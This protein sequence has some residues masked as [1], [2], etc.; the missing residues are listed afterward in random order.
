MRIR[1][2]WCLIGIPALSL[3]LIV[4]GCGGDCSST[5][6][7]CRSS[8]ESSPMS[9]V[10]VSEAG[11]HS[12]GITASGTA[13]CWG[14][15]DKG[16]LGNGTTTNSST[17][18]PVSGGLLFASVSVSSGAFGTGADHTCGVTKDGRAYCWGFNNFGQLGSRASEGTTTPIAVSGG[19]TFRAITT[20]AFH[21]CGI[22]ASGAAFCWG[23]NS[24]GQLGSTSGAAEPT[25]VAG[26]LT[27]SSLSAGAFHT[28]GLTAGVAYCWGLNL[29]GE[30]GDG[31]S[32]NRSTPVSGVGGRKFTSI[33]AKLDHT[34]G[35][36]AEG[37][38]YCWGADYKGGREV[39]SDARTLAANRDLGGYRVP[40]LVSALQSGTRPGDLN[41]DGAVDVLDLSI[42]LSNWNRTGPNVAD[43][44]GDG[45]VNVIDLGIMLSNWGLKPVV[46]LVHGI[47]G[48]PASF[49]NLKSLLSPYFEVV[50]YDY[51]FLT[52]R[53]TTTN[54]KIED[55]ATDFALWL[56]GRG[57]ATPKFPPELMGRRISIVAHSMG[58]LVVASYMAG[59]SN[60][61]AGTYTPGDFK[62]I[63]TLG[64]PYYGAKRDFLRTLLSI[65]CLLGAPDAGVQ[66]DEM[67]PA[68]EFT[69]LL[70]QALQNVSVSPGLL[71]NVAGSVDALGTINNETDGVVPIWSAVQAGGNA[72]TSPI[73]YL[74]CKHTP[75][76]P[77][78]PLAFSC[79][80]AD[81]ES[82]NDPSF[83]V[84]LRWLNEGANASPT[85]PPLSPL[86]ALAQ[87]M[88]LVR[89]EKENGTTFP[90]FTPDVELVTST[91]SV[92]G[93]SLFSQLDCVGNDNTGSL[94]IMRVPAGTEFAPSSQA[95]TVRLKNRPA[96]FAPAVT[97]LPVTIYPGRPAAVRFVCTPT[98]ITQA[99]TRGRIATVLLEELDNRPKG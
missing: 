37:K 52:V 80:L 48:S 88:L 16:Q 34:C 61:L 60:P 23:N 33:T 44:N 3:L 20:G 54:A 12:C 97:E 14:R 25:P 26:G 90:G 7:S 45:V 15:N 63:I 4:L 84:I 10:S 57:G 43:I 50:A 76:L 24:L 49:G 41:G 93:C 73:G 11:S 85:L 35:V 36:T 98:Q 79:N 67:L 99:Q 40:H 1:S 29:D 68:S 30:L 74:P 87:G 46:I 6:P 21:T 56:R 65:N 42:L 9:F 66:E 64:T 62:R 96:G 55:I 53:C 38:T 39:S 51:S 27:V 8:P 59:L 2:Q 78:V 69:W 95:Y 22:T 82:E 89:V 77:G 81:V 18:V 58:G 83:A 70:H 91:G 94:A 28:C 92:F 72:T 47:Y 17:P 71:M 86:R 13:Y 75:L 32:T 5:G 31:T 19:L